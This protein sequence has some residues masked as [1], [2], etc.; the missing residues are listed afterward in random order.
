MTRKQEKKEPPVRMSDLVLLVADKDIKSTV[1]GL[2]D[3]FA[4]LQIRPITTDRLVHPEHD[5]GCLKHS[6]DLLSL[7]LRTHSYAM[8]VFDQE[9]CGRDK[10]TRE[11]LEQQV[12]GQLEKSGWKDRVA[13]VVIDPELEMWVWSDSPHVATE[14]GWKDAKKGIRTWLVEQGFLDDEKQ[15]KPTRP[16][17]AMEAVLRKVKKP[18]SSAIYLSL[19]Q[20]VGLS[21]C[22]DSAFLRFKTIL[23]KWFPSS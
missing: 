5:P 2:I 9:G 7:Y 14:L 1:E 19:A 11:E 12:A 6:V 15:F 10:S 21:R 18:R 3:R 8:V 4:S 16:K 22:S 17:E 13:V 23:Q 20:K